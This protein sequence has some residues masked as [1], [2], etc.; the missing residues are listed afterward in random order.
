MS[1]DN[2]HDPACYDDGLDGPD[3]ESFPP[4]EDYEAAM[5]RLRE[6]ALDRLCDEDMRAEREAEHAHRKD[7]GACLE[8]GRF[9][10]GDQPCYD[11]GNGVL[12]A[13]LASALQQR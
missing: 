13:K 5:E 9:H 11:D 1:I 3:L 10:P 4:D 8:C 6:A 2:D 12:G 7:V